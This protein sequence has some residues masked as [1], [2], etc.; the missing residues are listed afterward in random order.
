MLSFQWSDLWSDLSYVMLWYIGF[1]SRSS[2]LRRMTGRGPK[3]TKWLKRSVL[4]F[5]PCCCWPPSSARQTCGTFADSSVPIHFAVGSFH[6]KMGQGDDPSWWGDFAVGD[7]LH[8][9]G[10]R[11]WPNY[12]LVCPSILI[13]LAEYDYGVQCSWF[14]TFCGYSNIFRYEYSFVSYLYLIF[15]IRIE[16]IRIIFCLT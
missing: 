2:L 11:G 16:Y 1:M 4:T 9:D 5:P 10:S 13:F 14:F 15:F 3:P 12:S 7:V 6:I 8:Q